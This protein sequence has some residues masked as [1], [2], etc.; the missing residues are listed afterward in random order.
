MQYGTQPAIFHYY[1]FP[2][3]FLDLLNEKGV[4]MGIVQVYLK[5]EILCP[6]IVHSKLINQKDRTT[7]E[8]ASTYEF[9]L[10]TQLI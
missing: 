6:I 1:G 4:L 5:G 8:T 3:Y 10:R 7:V 9:K 2:Q